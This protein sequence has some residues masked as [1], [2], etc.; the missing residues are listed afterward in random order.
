MKSL[1]W[2]GLLW[3]GACLPMPPSPPE[4][5]APRLSPAGAVPVAAWVELRWDQTIEWKA[6]PTAWAED[7]GLEVEVELHPQSV[8]MRGRPVWPAGVTIRVDLE[9]SLEGGA[10]VEFPVATSTA[11]EPV[12]TVV[13]PL[14]GEV[15]SRLAWVALGATEGPV[16][17]RTEG[18]VLRTRAAGAGIYAVEAEG[19][20]AGTC[21]E[22][23]YA[24][25]AESRPVGWIT[26]ASV[27]ERAGPR[28]EAVQWSARPGRL[29]AWIQADAAVR[30]GGRW[31]GC[32][33]EGRLQL[34][35]WPGR[36]LTV[37][38]VPT[39]SPACEVEVE[40]WLEDL[41]GQRTETSTRLWTPPEVAAVISELV[42]SP[43]H[44]WGDSEPA[45]MPFD[46]LPGAGT[47]STADEWVELVNRSAHPLD[48]S[49]IGLELR[50]LDGT[51]STTAV[52]EAPALYFGAGGGPASWQ[53]G[54]ALVVRTRGAMSQTEL[55]VELW[56]G[57]VLLDRVRIGTEVDSDH[58]GGAPP[59]LQHEALGRGWDGYL[60]WCV[61]S[62]GSALPS[63]RCF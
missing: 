35:G 25:W 45:G 9:A 21:P 58:P 37:A 62:P 17:L 12:P 3:A 5:G 38:A 56:A 41:S 14:E 16:E 6:P 61:P 46:G 8:R 7:R 22:T 24:I 36:R 19:P 30:P 11:A 50:T 15:P 40:V 39:P 52:L 28:V 47:V 4:T 48:L 53:P 49:Q 44:D 42:P 34:E 59:D 1:G 57:A 63:E 43:R 33:G 60:R 18:H 23:R 54:E 20:C 26:T 32:G 13:S 55:Q 27:A 10:V 29:G 31:W 51:P 2:V